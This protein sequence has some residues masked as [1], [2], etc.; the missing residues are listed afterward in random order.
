MEKDQLEA[1]L[2]EAKIR[3]KGAEGKEAKEAAAREVDKAESALKKVEE[4]I[5]QEKARRQ[6][7]TYVDPATAT[8]TKDAFKENK[9]KIDELK[10]E[11]KFDETSEER[12]LAIAEEIIEL[13]KK[14]KDVAYEAKEREG[15]LG[16][17]G[18]LEK[19]GF[20]AS[21]MLGRLASQNHEAG[22][23]IRKQY[24]KAAKKT[25][26]DARDDALKETV[27]KAVK[28]E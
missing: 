9:D 3:E 25:K 20:L 1:T 27:E 16:Y 4:K 10:R 13:N 23:A 24:E 7:G 6:S 15:T 22:K 11:F 5:K 19:R 8:S 14:Q 12:R 26:E 2:K 28:K 17:A 21:A 18:V